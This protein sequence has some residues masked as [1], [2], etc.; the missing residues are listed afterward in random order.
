MSVKDMSGKDKL[1]V[2]GVLFGI[3]VGS[4]GHHYW[5]VAVK[6]LERL[7]AVGVWR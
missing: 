4:L 5:A 1:L 2:V 7:V 6:V 3:A